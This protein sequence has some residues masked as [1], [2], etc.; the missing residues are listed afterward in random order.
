MDL[1]KPLDDMIT[2]KKR[3]NN[4]NSNNNGGANKP[5]QSRERRD[6]PYAVCLLDRCNRLV[7]ADIVSDPLHD[8][9]KTSG[10]M[11]LSQVREEGEVEP[12]MPEEEEVG[13]SP[14]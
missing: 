4:S 10:Y 12:V 8:Q 9:Q 11:T 7:Y 1:D 13:R 3:S 6:V 14:M 5:R 2:S